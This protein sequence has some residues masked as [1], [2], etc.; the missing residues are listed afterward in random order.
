MVASL[1][2]IVDS[3]S[4]SYVG[5]KF[6]RSVVLP[7]RSLWQRLVVKNGP[8]KVKKNSIDFICEE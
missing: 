8:K 3:Y 4:G 6:E 7:P 5:G 1:W 2:L